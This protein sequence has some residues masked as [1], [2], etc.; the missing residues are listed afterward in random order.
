MFAVAGGSLVLDQAAKAA[1]RLFLQPESSVALIPG[2]A[3]LRLSFNRGA[4]FGL[5]PS[6]GPLF[7]VIAI[8]AIYAI[9]R[10]RHAATT[11][12][13]SVGLGLLLGGAVGNLLDR[14]VT[15]GRGVTDFIDLRLGHAATALSW[16]TFNIADAAL[17]IG[18]F[19]T[20]LSA[21]VHPEN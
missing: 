6:F 3:Y 17:V 15:P 7:I 21:K 11:K 18:V 2:F 9:V 12:S 1:A 10:L 19:I 20:L 14:L 5:M 8:V 4:A 13:L 16:P